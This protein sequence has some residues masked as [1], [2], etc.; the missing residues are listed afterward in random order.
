MRE[1]EYELDEEL[2]EFAWKLARENTVKNEQG[3]TVIPKG[4]EWEDEDWDIELDE[5]KKRSSNVPRPKEIWFAN[6]PHEENDGQSEDRPALVISA[7]KG[8]VAFLAMKITKNTDR[9]A[10]NFNQEKKSKEENHDVPLFNW[11]SEGLTIPSV[12][13]VDK[14]LTIDKSQFRRRVGVISEKDWRSVVREM[15]QVYNKRFSEKV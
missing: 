14:M 7:D 6:Y 9:F 3:L 12:V 11:E 8:S 2:L 4:D 1:E 15:R 5:V 10:D 13:R